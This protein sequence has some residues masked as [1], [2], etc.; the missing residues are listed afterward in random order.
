MA[1]G[2][3]GWLI[4]DLS[5]PMEKNGSCVDRKRVAVRQR[6]GPI[7]PLFPFVLGSIV[8]AVIFNYKSYYYGIDYQCYS[9]L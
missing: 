4:T 6:D 5:T 8:F 7:F 3:G 9:F 1:T 2:P